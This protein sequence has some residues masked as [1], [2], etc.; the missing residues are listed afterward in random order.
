MRIHSLRLPFSF[1]HGKMLLELTQIPDC[2]WVPHH[3]QS[4]FEGDWSGIAL[5]SSTGST[6]D[7]YVRAGDYFDTPLLSACEYFRQVLEHFL[8]PLTSV[9]LLRLHAGSMIKEHSDP[10]LG[11]EDG[12]VRIHVPIQTH[13]DVFFYL[14]RRRVVLQEGEAW[15]LDLSRPHRIENRAPVDRIHLVIDAVVNDWVRCLFQAAITAGGGNH[16][17]P[18]VVTAFDRFREVVFKEPELQ[19]QLLLT[20]DRASFVELAVELGRDRGYV[21]DRDLVES[22]IRRGREAWNDRWVNA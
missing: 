13:A 12:E 21:F 22:A 6:R 14:D 1:D 7:L 20:P 10:A 11:F 3:N 17:P 2:D 19:E 18:E 8:C 4:D 15:Y 16:L 9:R 5:R